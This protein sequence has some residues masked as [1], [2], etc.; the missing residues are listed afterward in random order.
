MSIHYAG[1]MLDT[2]ILD[3]PKIF[4]SSSVESDLKGE[5]SKLYILKY[6]IIYLKLSN[7]LDTSPFRLSKTMQGQGSPVA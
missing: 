1:K 7:V 4:Y 2:Y 3:L 5:K 6:C